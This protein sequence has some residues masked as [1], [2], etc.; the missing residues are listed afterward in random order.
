MKYFTLSYILYLSYP[1]SKPVV[2]V[3]MCS[4]QSED[5]KTTVSGTESSPSSKSSK[6]SGPM[7][8]GREGRDGGVVLGAVLVHYKL[9]ITL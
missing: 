2:R 1:P 6:T 9:V 8:W 3:Y 7:N 4:I 5:S